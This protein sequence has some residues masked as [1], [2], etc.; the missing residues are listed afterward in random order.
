MFPPPLH[1]G[2]T[3]WQ[4]LSNNF[5]NEYQ[6]TNSNQDVK[7]NH[8]SSIVILEPLYNDSAIDLAC[9]GLLA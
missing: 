7:D 2:I 6:N 3:L 4:F 5:P 1:K 8:H 9:E